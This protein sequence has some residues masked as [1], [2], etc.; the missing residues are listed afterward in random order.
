MIK[1][2][3]LTILITLVLATG[4]IIFPIAAQFIIGW[5]IG[6]WAVNLANRVIGGERDAR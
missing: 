6:G 3:A 5:Q 2:Y 4:V 1:Y